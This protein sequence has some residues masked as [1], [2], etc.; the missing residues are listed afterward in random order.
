MV[1]K[2]IY[3]FFI[4]FLSIAL[5]ACGGSSS[6]SATSH[7]NNKTD[8]SDTDDSNENQPV[9]SCNFSTLE[10]TATKSMVLPNNGQ[11]QAFSQHNELIANLTN[12]MYSGYSD[13]AHSSKQLKEKVG[14]YCQSDTSM[15]DLDKRAAAQMAFRVAMEDVQYSIG[16]TAKGQ[17]LDPGRDVENGIEVIYSWPLTNKCS[18]DKRLAENS[19]SP[20][21]LLS[22]KGLDALEYL[23]FVDP[24]ANSICNESDLSDYQKIKYSEFNALSD[25]DKQVRRC[26]YMVE[27]ADGVA[28]T[29]K[30]LKEAWDPAVGN[31]L[32]QVQATTQPINILDDISDAMYYLA[33][34]GK[35]DKLA[36]PMGSGRANTISSCGEGEPCPQDL[37]SPDAR[38]S[39]DNLIAN[40][41]SFQELYFGGQAADKAANI[42]FDDWLITIGEVEVANRISDDIDEVLTGLNNLKTEHGDLYTAVSVCSTDMET[43][44]D[45]VFQNLTRGYR[46]LFLSRLGL[47]PPQS[48]LADND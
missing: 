27:V 14:D 2:L 28:D 33:D 7:D 30:V 47:N 25:A 8:D 24:S 46:Q 19:A 9:I 40:T 26:N 4:L 16:H 41:R 1:T 34:I 23:L 39:I 32:G 36:Q 31:Y 48:S 3:P 6:S 44:Y 13:L 12:L 15:A 38:L 35:E 29:A 42:G 20:G 21:S 37:E 5:S 11:G 18:I 45:G 10:N 17:G 43:F 22:R